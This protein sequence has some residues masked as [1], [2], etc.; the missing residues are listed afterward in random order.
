MSGA[1]SH[2]DLESVCRQYFRLF[3]GR[4]QEVNFSTAPFG[5]TFGRFSL[6]KGEL[7]FD[8]VV[9]AQQPFHDLI[10]H[11]WL[12]TVLCKEYPYS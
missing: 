2:V 1:R 8:Y 10:H 6:N 3:L 9:E 5:D 4:E 11:S 7:R 12:I